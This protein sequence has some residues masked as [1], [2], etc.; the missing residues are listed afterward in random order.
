MPK[1][2]QRGFILTSLVSEKNQ[3]LGTIILEN[4]EKPFK[5]KELERD[6]SMTNL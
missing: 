6:Q 1:G 2:W 5:H 4:C 3:H